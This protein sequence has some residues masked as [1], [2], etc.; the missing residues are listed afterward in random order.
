MTLKSYKTF[1]AALTISAVLVLAFA[2]A[3]CGIYKFK[4]VSIPD[5]IRIVR[6]GIIQNKASYVNPQLAPELT[7]SLKRKITSQT[8]LKQT[9][10]DDADWDINC[11]ITSY[12]FSTSGI[13]NQRANTNR[14][15]VGVH[16]DVRDNHSQK[17]SKYD[18]TRSFDYNGT[19]A[20]QQAE[21][22]LKT[23]MLRS[24]SD[25]VFNRIFSNW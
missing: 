23:E 17:V 19:L 16:V 2:Q 21:Q 18:V 11:T 8:R 22:E 3:G 5:S 9:N 7:E 20:L 10:G 25:D 4:D 13:S 15:N 1:F 12:S 14:L 6:V 24:L